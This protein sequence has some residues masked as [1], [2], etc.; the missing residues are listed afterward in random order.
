MILGIANRLFLPFK[1]YITT[2]GV[3]GNF[4]IN[5]NSDMNIVKLDVKGLSKYPPLFYTVWG[6]KSFFFFRER[7]S[8][9]FP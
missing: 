2:E 5:I 8:E 4:S 6:V 1:L 3:S 9:K 7:K